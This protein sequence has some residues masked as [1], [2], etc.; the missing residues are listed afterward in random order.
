MPGARLGYRFPSKRLSSP[1]GGRSSP[2]QSGPRASQYPR[3][4]VQC[5]RW[6]PPLRLTGGRS[7]HVGWR[8][9]ALRSVNRHLPGFSWDLAPLHEKRMAVYQPTASSM[10]I[11]YQILKLLCMI[12]ERILRKIFEQYWSYQSI[13]KFVWVCIIL[14][15]FFCSICKYIGPALEAC[16]QHPAGP[17][18]MMA[19]CQ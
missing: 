12:S 7:G 18:T 8:A 13:T 19:T 6:L 11:F 10:P 4:P 3:D 2:P 14:L 16:C 17:A 1:T 15:L 5:Q 9:A